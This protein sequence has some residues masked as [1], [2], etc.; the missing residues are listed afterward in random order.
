VDPRQTVEVAVGRDD[1]SDAVAL[2][3]GQM[4][5]VARLERYVNGSERACTL[6]VDIVHGEDA[7]SKGP[8][9]RV[10]DSQASV[11]LA[12]AQVAVKNFLQRL[13]TR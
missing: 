7:P 9:K 5:E 12:S 2:H 4:E 13:D 3:D 8:V 11:S 10:E 1:V 6:H